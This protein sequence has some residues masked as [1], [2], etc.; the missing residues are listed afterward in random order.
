MQNFSSLYIQI[1]NNINRLHQ[2]FEKVFK[3]NKI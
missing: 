2:V 3:E 1:L